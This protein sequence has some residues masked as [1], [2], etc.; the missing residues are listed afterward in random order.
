MNAGKKIA[1]NLAT[2]TL[3]LKMACLFLGVSRI[4]LWRYEIANKIKPIEIGRRKF[5]RKSDLRMLQSEGFYS[6]NEKAGEKIHIGFN[7]S[8]YK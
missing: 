1:E 5:Y 7:E 3:D 6:G 4:S 8:E 2:E